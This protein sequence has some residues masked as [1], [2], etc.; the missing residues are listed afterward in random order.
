MCFCVCVCVCMRRCMCMCL[1]MCVVY[2]VCMYA[3]RVCVCTWVWCVCAL[4]SLC[5]C[6]TLNCVRLVCSESGGVFSLG[7][8]RGGLIG[9]G[10]WNSLQEE[11]ERYRKQLES[12][13]RKLKSEIA[14]IITSFDAK[15]LAV[16]DKKLK[17]PRGF[18]WTCLHVALFFL[19]QSFGTISVATALNFCSWMR[20]SSSQNC[21][22]SSWLRQC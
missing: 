22:S 5:L 12:E 8:D 4:S 14:D 2:Y 6:A 9:C 7:E 16:L 18:S 19:L 3:I 1:C 21:S 13:S 17:V 10:G 15:L 11:K 20:I